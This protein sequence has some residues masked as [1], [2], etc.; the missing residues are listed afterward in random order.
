MEGG[1]LDLGPKNLEV[2][3]D[4]DRDE[5]LGGELAEYLHAMSAEGSVNSSGI[6]TI[7]VRAAL[8]KL[9][10]FQLP[11]P[12][13]GILK[14]V[15]SAVASGASFVETDFGS[16]GI[17]IEHDG[18]PPNAEELRDLLSYLLSSNRAADERALRDLAVG[19]NTS[20]ARGASWV[21]VAARTDIGW[22]RQRWASRDE[23]AQLELP[24]DGG[25]ATVR[26]VVRNSAGQ[27]ASGLWGTLAKKDIQG[28]L[29]G[30]RDEMS[31]DAQAVFDR[32]RYA[33][34]V[35]RINGRTVP[36]ASFGQVVTRR[37]SA[38]TTLEHRQANLLEFYLQASEE[39][40][41]LMSAPETSQARHRFSLTGLFDG[42]EFEA[43]AFPVLVDGPLA[44]RRC[45]AILGLRGKSNVPGEMIVVKDGVELT[46]LT[47]P[48]FPKGV[49]AVVTAEGLRLDLSQF[50][51]IDAPETR[52]RVRWLS[53]AASLAARHTLKLSMEGELS[54]TEHE[55]LT[56]LANR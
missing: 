39:S 30:S 18:I 26:F 53:Q 32:C 54:A 43:Q 16:T 25:K 29:T 6:F 4:G 20:L 7:D 55:F 36:S 12:H 21:E 33:P 45:F 19:V 42:R 14:V 23:S 2:L 1:L 28:M 5:S 10:K 38:F 27:V 50:R 24:A 56:T 46:R 31:E 9:E 3:K 22:V 44:P 34:A 49:S 47:P 13:F 48:S 8:P 11:R 35:V 17:T 40:P 41:H 37:W 51:L 52:E 15:Q